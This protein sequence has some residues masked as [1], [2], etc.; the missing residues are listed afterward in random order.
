MGILI[1]SES[2]GNTNIQILKVNV[3]KM[4][5]VVELAAVTTA[6][7]YIISSH[8]VRTLTKLDKFGK[9][10]SDLAT[11]WHHSDDHKTWQIW[12]GNA[13][14]SNGEEIK[15]TDV[16]DSIQKQLALKTGVHFPF[17][18]IEKVSLNQDNSVTIKLKT[19]RTDFVYDLSKSEFGVL[20]KSDVLAKKGESGFAISSGPYFILKRE[21]SEYHL[22]RNRYFK[23]EQGNDL[24]LIIGNSDGEASPKALTNG[25]IDFFTTQQNLSASQHGDIEAVKGLSAT[26][27]HVAFSY[28]LSL[29]SESEYF[30]HKE[31]R[32][33]FQ[34]TVKEFKSPELNN[35]SW[36]VAE[37]LYL[38]DGDGRPSDDE[39]ASAWRSIAR[40]ADTANSKAKVKLRIVPLKMT[41][42]LISELTSYLSKFYEIETISYNTEDELIQ[43]IRNGKFDIKISSNDFSS[44]DLSENLKTTFNASRPYVFL[45]K[46]S[47]VKRL[48][49][50]AATLNDKV[51]QSLIYKKIG[52]SLL[53]EG[54]IAPLAYQRVWFYHKKSIDI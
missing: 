2:F 54:L 18:E 52:L 43:I 12:I 47:P 22:K 33:K 34:S 7:H 29:N 35:H 8:L 50:K 49:A 19:P 38:P 44:I 42:T 48:M 11:K 53:E 37:Q 32:A 45:S 40:L 5:E 46:T 24:D 1:S 30:R 41:N 10:Q 15:A 17:S 51:E 28:W 26:K 20:H 23:S 27:P 14:F 13:K 39:L 31:N 16:V 21:A 25:T 6:G 36:Q 4:P 3:F 9:I